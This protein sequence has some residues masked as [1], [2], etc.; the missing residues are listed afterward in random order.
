MKRLSVSWL[1]GTE[2]PKASVIIGMA[3]KYKSVEIGIK[4]N[5][6]V[7][8]ANVTTS[9]LELLPWRSLN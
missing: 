9:L 7:S 5:N 6:P 3:G 8:V 2:V 4:A 1:L